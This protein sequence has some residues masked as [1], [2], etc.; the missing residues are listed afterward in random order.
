MSLQSQVL[1]NSALSSTSKPGDLVPVAREETRPI[2]SAVR[3]QE[4][5]PVANQEGVR[6]PWMGYARVTLG[7]AIWVRET[8]VI[9]P[10]A[11][12][13]VQAPTGLSG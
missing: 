1:P 10:T 6:V 8:K 4:P 9:Q 5:G 12:V 11:A 2:V 3:Q 13:V 7:W